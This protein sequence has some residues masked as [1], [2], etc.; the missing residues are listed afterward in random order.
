MRY[1]LQVSKLPQKYC[2]NDFT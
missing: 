1:I 2:T